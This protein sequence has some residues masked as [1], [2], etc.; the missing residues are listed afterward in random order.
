[1]KIN[2]LAAIVHEA[3]AVYC[4]SIN[5]NSQHRWVDTPQNIKESAIDGVL[6][7]SQN[8]ELPPSASHANWLSFKTAEGWVYGETKSLEHKTHPCMMAYTDLPEAQKAKDAL[9]HAIV[10]VFLDELEYD[11][12]ADGTVVPDANVAVPDSVSGAQ[13]PSSAQGPGTDRVVLA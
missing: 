2:D 7:V 1:M 13:G 12:F 8:P 9:F 5:D 11:E 3:T 10:H 4:R 6:F